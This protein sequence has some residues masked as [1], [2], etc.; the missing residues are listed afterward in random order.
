MRRLLALLAVTVISFCSCGAPV[1]AAGGPVVYVTCDVRPQPNRLDLRDW[2]WE[3]HR[4]SLL[5]DS[6]LA[7]TEAI[8][9]SKC[10][11]AGMRHKPVGGQQVIVVF[12]GMVE[13]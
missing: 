4:S 2:R 10:F 3:T 12:P 5:L 13:D 9:R 6:G 8:A 11:K 7:H 1:V